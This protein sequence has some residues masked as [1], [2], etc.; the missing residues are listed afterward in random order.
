MAADTVAVNGYAVRALRHAR[1]MKQQTLAVAAELSPS[2]LSEIES[3][4][5][6]NVSRDVLGRLMDAL[7]LRPEDERA[8]TRWWTVAEL[9][10]EVA[11]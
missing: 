1:H 2:Y 7:F 3:S 8:L 4:A 6:V 9:A 11:A 5:K 10:G